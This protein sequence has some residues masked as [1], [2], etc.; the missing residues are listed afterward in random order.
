MQ[1]GEV[2]THDEDFRHPLWGGSEDENE[3]NRGS[4]RTDMRQM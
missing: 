2:Q 1:S 4:H 3:G